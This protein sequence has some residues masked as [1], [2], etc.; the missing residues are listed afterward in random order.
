MNTGM[1]SLKTTLEARTPVT[2]PLVEATER[3]AAL[4]HPLQIL[5]EGLVAPGHH[6][7]HP[8]GH[9][10]QCPGEL[11][12]DRAGEP[13]TPVDG[14]DQVRDLRPYPGQIRSVD[15]PRP[16]GDLLGC[17]RRVGPAKERGEL[18]AVR[19]ADDRDRIRVRRHRDHIDVARWGWLRRS[20]TYANTS[21][22][23]LLTS[24]LSD[25]LG[26]PHCPPATTPAPRGATGRV[27]WTDRRHIS[28][29]VAFARTAA[30]A[31]ATECASWASVF[32]PWPVS[33]HPDPGGELRWDIDDVVSIS[34]PLHQGQ[35]R[36]V[37]ALDRPCPLRPGSDV[38][39]P[40][41]ATF[42]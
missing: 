11:Q 36:A 19:L 21:A 28:R 9:Q 17:E 40:T 39:A 16:C 2:K 27:R 29:G 7:R 4:Q 35:A 37:A 34:Q 8:R 6:Q 24:T 42:V 15:D 14:L 22:G 38:L 20:A 31:T 32:R 26:T 10:P 33:K 18:D 1:A 5:D 25:D 12:I 13:G 3:S 30:T 23:G 41:T